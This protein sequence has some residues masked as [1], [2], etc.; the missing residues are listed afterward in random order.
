MIT[1]YR[2]YRPQKWSEAV[3]QNH[4]KVT[5]ENELATGRIAHA[6]LF[7][8]PRAVGKTTSARLLAKSLSCLKR[9]PGESEPCNECEA[10]REITEGRSFD[11]IEIDAASNTGVDNVRDNI[12]ASARVVPAKNK[13]KVFIIDEVHMLSPSAFN[14]LLK[15]MEEP[16]EFVVFILCTTEIHKVPNTIISRCQRFDFKRIGIND[17][18]KRLTYIA[19]ADEIKVDKEVLEMIARQSEG[20]M[21]DAESLLGQ[22]V[23]L[24]GKEIT[25]AE[26]D[27]VI[28]RT[29]LGEAI[30][31]IGYLAKKD[32]GQGIKLVN[33]LLDNGI[34][35]KTFTTNLVEILRK[36]LIA[37]INP[38]LAEKLVL[39]LGESLEI[40]LNEAGRDLTPE[41]IAVWLERFSEARQQIKN[42]F[43]LQ[44]PLEL[45]IIELTSERPIL[46]SNPVPAPMSAPAPSAPFNPANFRPQMFNARPAV[47]VNQTTQVSPAPKVAVANPNLT[48][49]EIKQKW[50]EVLVKIKRY[51]HSLSFVLRACEP[52]DLNGNQLCLAFKYKFHK[53]RVD[54]PQIKPLVENVLQEVYGNPLFIEALIDESLEISANANGDNPV[55]VSVTLEPAI[56]VEA[57]N[58]NIEK[59]EINPTE[60]PAIDNLLKTFGGRIVK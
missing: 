57:E 41:K 48:A 5:L 39:E 24:G 14:A 3:G 9:Q 30:N 7:C 46:K 11:V 1:L 17:M 37:K 20:H 16:P 54:S 8:G 25:R 19:R 55:S 47:A 27:L 42:S 52:R 40:K 38:A 28:P 45:A 13:Y 6:Y 50:S 29:D 36:L 2:K 10:C 12:I 18:V 26:A 21:R 53:E 15:I 51:N 58:N 32:A 35:L 31:L 23:S 43:I 60:N 22:L 33:D 59:E 56:D 34:D 49:E 44:M 4:I